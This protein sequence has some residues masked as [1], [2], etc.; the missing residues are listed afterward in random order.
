MKVRQANLDPELSCAPPTAV[1]ATPSC[2]GEL[3]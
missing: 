3:A 1:T 2:L